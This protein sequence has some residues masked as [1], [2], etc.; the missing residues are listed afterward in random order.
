MPKRTIIIPPFTEPA[1]ATPAEFS[2]D[3]F[4]AVIQTL[5]EGER[6]FGK[7]PNDDLT[8]DR[9]LAKNQQD[10]AQR[11][12]M[13]HG[14]GNSAEAHP[15]LSNSAYFSGIDQAVNPSLEHMTDEEKA[16]FKEELQYQQRKQ[17]EKRL[18]LGHGPSSAPILTR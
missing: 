5:R 4:V 7:T 10:V 12:E 1:T 17:L 15:I 13:E 14:R 9:L 3:N 16:R 6:A 8:R 2:V 11:G 18:A